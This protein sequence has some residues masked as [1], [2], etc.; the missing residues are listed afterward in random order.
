MYSVNFTWE[1]MVIDRLPKDMS[2]KWYRD[3]NFTLLFKNGTNFIEI[4][5][6]KLLYRISLNER[7]LS[8]I[9]YKK[10]R[11]MESYYLPI[12][13]KFIDGNVYMVILK[14]NHA[15]KKLPQRIKEIKAITKY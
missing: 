11:F 12:S 13:E 8:I 7:I 5:G 3:N 2:N 14:Y 15:R 9:Y 6:E 10:K 1:N 4:K